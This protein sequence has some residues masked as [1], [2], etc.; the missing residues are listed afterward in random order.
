M[1]T[2]AITFL[3]KKGIPFEV[4][5]YE[6]E[7]KGAKFAARAT[8]FSLEQTVKTLVVELEY[9]NYCVA[10]M[11][12][13]RELNLKRLAKVFA[14]K[15]AAMVDAAAAERLTGYLV[16]GISPFG[17]KHRLP[18][19]MDKSI[20][21]FGQILINAGQ[22]GVMLKMTPNDILNTLNCRVAEIAR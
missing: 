2:R 6:H 13:H 19:V 21:N 11:P 1:S 18:V 15:S 3:S 10:L 22:R 14:V 5:K 7:E 16:G 12:G 17:T 8:G 9:D 4:L 20:L